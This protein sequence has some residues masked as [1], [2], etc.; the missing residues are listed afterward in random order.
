MLRKAKKL[1]SIGAFCIGT[2]QI[3][4]LNASKKGI[5]CYNAPYS[6]TRS[7]VE[8]VIAYIF[9][10]L[11]KLTDKNNSTHLGVWDK[12]AAGS[13]EVRGKKLGIVGYG[14]IGSQLSSMAEAVGM[15]VFFY[16][17]SDKLNRGNA[18][19]CN[20]LKELLNKVDIVSI[21]VY[22]SPENV[23]LIGK[24]QLA[25]MKKGSYLINA[26]RGEIV[27]VKAL[28]AG[29]QSGHLAGAAVDVFPEE[30]KKIGEKFH[31]PLQGLSNVIMT[32]HIG[33]STEEAQ[34][35][36]AFFV[37]KRLTQFMNNGDTT[38]SVNFPNIQLPPVKNCSRIIHIHKNS[39][40]KLAKINS[41]L[42]REKINIEGQYLKTN[43]DIG[44]VIVDV[45]TK[46]ARSLI[47]QL[48]EIPDTIKVRVLY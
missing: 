26:S 9:S 32:P 6:N 31:S 20:S 36:I 33:G 38:L 13:F 4:L 12:N 2:N 43:E 44:Y 34:K 47:T 27:D 35:D 29:L 24:K 8:L 25:Q 37:S 22:S 18:K 5:A 16:N 3:D 1:H 11:R 23:N 28:Q 19:R 30:P 21:H 42:A 17:R 10:L 39:P 45:N 15:Q 48:K 14:N 7:V 40:G 46:P 41:I